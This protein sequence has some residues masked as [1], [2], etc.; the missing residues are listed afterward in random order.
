MDRFSAGR[1]LTLVITLTASLP[2]FGC[3][4]SD[5]PTF[6]VVRAEI[7]EESEDGFV[8]TFTLRGDNSRDVALP[9]RRINYSVSLDGERVFEGRR[10][11]EATLPRKGSQFIQLPAAVPADIRTADSLRGEIPFSINANLTYLAPGLLAE[12]LFDSKVVQPTVNFVERGVLRA[13]EPD[14]VTPS[15]PSPGE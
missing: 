13:G 6:E 8:V 2:A 5:P 3:A 9:L 10:D 14:D 7:T 4:F 15:S 1:I 12:V 11:A